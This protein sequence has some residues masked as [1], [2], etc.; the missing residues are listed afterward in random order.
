M[1]SFNPQTAAKEILRDLT[2]V[3]TSTGVTVRIGKKRG[4]LRSIVITKSFKGY[5]AVRKSINRQT[6]KLYGEDCVLMI[7]DTAVN[8]KGGKFSNELLK[9]LERCTTE[10]FNGGDHLNEDDNFSK[11]LS[12]VKNTF[13]SPEIT[14]VDL[15]PLAAQFN[16]LDKKQLALL[17]EQLAAHE[18]FAAAIEDYQEMVRLIAEQD[19]EYNEANGVTDVE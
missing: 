2:R 1:K 11:N 18:N 8:F 7:G 15:V 10:F 9:M 5:D 13:L 19:A 4:E 17:G 14:I 12:I 3:K 6:E 16:G